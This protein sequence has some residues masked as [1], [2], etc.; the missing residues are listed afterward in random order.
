M[1]LRSYKPSFEALEERWTPATLTVLNAADDGAGSLRAA[2]ASASDGDTIVFGP[3]LQNQ[4]IRLTSGPILLN[5]ALTLQGLGADRLRIQGNGTFRLFDI[6]DGT[7]L[8]R[9]V[10][11]SG[12]TLSGG[13][14]DGGAIR[15]FEDLKLTDCVITGNRALDY[16]G[17]G[18]GIYNAGPD[19]L[20]EMTRCVVSN[21]LARYGGGIANDGTALITEC[22][23][24]G[25]T[26]AQSGQFASGGGILNTGALTVHRS[27]ISGNVAG[28]TSAGSSGLGGGL[29]NRGNALLVNTTISGNV[30]NGPGTGYG[31]AGVSMDGYLNTG[32]V[33]EN[34]TITA[35]K[36][37]SGAGGGGIR[38]FTGTVT[39]RNTIVAGNTTT[40]AANGHDLHNLSPFGVMPVHAFNSLFGRLTST[41]VLAT[42][43]N[44]LKGTNAAPLD[45]KLGALKNNGGPTAT[46]AL[47]AGS[48]AIN[49]G[50][51]FSGA[52]TV[53]QRGAGFNRRIDGTTDIGAVEYQ[54][55]ATRTVLTSSATSSRLGQVV[56]FTA[57]VS[58]LAANSNVPQGTV[59]FFVAG[60]AVATVPLVNGRATFSTRSFTLGT[61]QVKAVYNG[62]TLGDYRFD[63]SI[64][65]VIDLLVR[66]F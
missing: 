10:K 13:Y 3:S 49:A 64:S 7:V 26:A 53:D 16:F 50:G 30:V 4:T 22:T 42:D 40:T 27:T 39:L 51:H 23:I 32:I 2:I 6:N 54:P 52:P 38:V 31:G 57:Q 5:K 44:N 60:R 55:P 45:P 14:G 59:T 63:T 65:A 35:N 43:V 25:N 41:A 8:E 48:P 47:L 15:N 61:N 24:A 62:F 29:E 46:H 21:N 9:K 66:R 12:V 11:I 18:G 17:T 20:L 33:L 58:G 1:G 28:S 36:D 19:A 37:N 34:C 56:T